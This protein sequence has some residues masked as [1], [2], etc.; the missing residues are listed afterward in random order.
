[1][2]ILYFCSW[3]DLNAKGWILQKWASHAHNTH[4]IQWSLNG[5]ERKAGC[6][7]CLGEAPNSGKL[8]PG[9]LPVGSQLHHITCLHPPPERAG[10]SLPLPILAAAVIFLH[11]HLPTFLAEATEEELVSEKR[12]VEDL[13]SALRLWVML[14]GGR[15]MKGEILLLPD[16]EVGTKRWG[17]SSSSGLR[18]VGITI[19]SGTRCFR[20]SPAAAVTHLPGALVG[21]QGCSASQEDLLLN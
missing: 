12:R 21:R 19:E 5:W 4:H 10:L 14:K 20:P 15:E 2:H 6:A 3:E 9:W 7:E 17:A 1:M 8:E 18:G 16:S 13:C 11:Q